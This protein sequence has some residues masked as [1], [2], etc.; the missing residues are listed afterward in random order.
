[1]N[2]FDNQVTYKYKIANSLTIP[3]KYLYLENGE[4][5]S[6]KDYIK[7]YIEYYTF[8]QI[9]TSLGLLKIQLSNIDILMIYVYAASEMNLHNKDDNFMSNLLNEISTMVDENNNSLFVMYVSVDSF[10]TSFNIWFANYEREIHK[11]NEIYDKIQDVQ[12]TLNK[13]NPLVTS[14]LKI[15]S[16]DINYDVLF[17]NDQK[18]TLEDCLDIFVSAIPT[19]QVP[20][21]QYN[22]ED[23]E[24]LIRVYKGLS[25]DNDQIPLEFTLQ[26]ITKN[27]KNNSFYLTIHTGDE[28][29]TNNQNAYLK[30]IYN[31]EK[32]TINLPTRDDNNWSERI[33]TRF[34]ESFPMLKLVQSKEN[35]IEGEFTITGMSLNPEVLHV[36]TINDRTISTYLYIDET[37]VPFCEKKR[38]SLHYRS[39]DFEDNTERDED[40]EIDN[41]SNATITFPALP[42]G[43]LLDQ[44]SKL[45]EETGT[46]K[47]QTIKVHLRIKD[48]KILNQFM[49][50]FPRL[51]AYYM[52]I[53]PKII[54]FLNTITTEESKN[55]IKLTRE[56]TLIYTKIKNLT[57]LAPEIFK[58]NK[59]ES[60]SVYSRR[61][62]CPY[63]PIIIS[64][65]EVE[66]WR[67]KYI[68]V[69]NEF[70]HRTVL[71]F[72]N[73][74][75]NQYH[76]VCPSDAYPIPYGIKNNDPNYSFIP[77]CAK[78]DMNK[79][80][81]EKVEEYK[82]KIIVEKEIPKSKE[83]YHTKSIKPQEPGRFG[84]L[85]KSLLS[86]LQA[87][88]SG[89]S[90]DF[91]H[92]GIIKSTSS[93]IHCL[94]ISTGDPNYNQYLTSIDK[95]NYVLA[96]RKNIADNIN[97]NVFKQEMYNYSLQQIKELLLNK[98]V[99]LDPHL[100]YRGLEEYFG[101]N[102]YVFNPEGPANPIEGVTEDT[103][104]PVLEIPRCI[105][106]HIRVSRPDRKT[107]IILKYPNYNQCELIVT[108]GIVINESIIPDTD[109]DDDDQSECCSDKPVAI[110]TQKYGNVPKVMGE[111]VTYI[112]DSSMEKVLYNS[113]KNMLDTYSINY[114]HTTAITKDISETYINPKEIVIHHNL[115]NRVNWLNVLDKVQILRQK[116]DSYGKTRM[117]EV[118]YQG[119]IVI[120]DWSDK[121]DI[122]EDVNIEIL[123]NTQNK[124]INLTYKEDKY[125]CTLYT[126]NKCKQNKTMVFIK[127]TR[128]CDEESTIIYKCICGNT[129][130]N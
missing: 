48:R 69:N 9:Y 124:T 14:E 80:R 75:A 59:N 35:K 90:Y 55:K 33:K 71:D 5:K 24:P 98:E 37:G 67:N 39:A 44:K 43:T 109:N 83:K 25:E 7:L 84:T 40:T 15:T 79:E 73:N 11:E 34:L 53:K 12:T 72:P 108:R 128:R 78:S 64:N 111:G 89:S 99:F 28:E 6:L 42:E 68:Q 115:Y 61:C 23:Q 105:I 47:N 102:I 36:L 50:I 121:V 103:T 4:F 13:T 116:I 114:P 27:D 41:S 65:D 30:I 88:F 51:M 66:A 95:E 22:Q 87:A 130:K 29:Y 3:S 129:W 21:I 113:L 62:T 56:N 57:H 107:V 77:C 19:A 81:L 119:N 58:D 63:Q 82:Q 117:L 52:Y 10:V 86:L 60:N 31:L 101:V 122:N 125:K 104:G 2:Q 92:W 32:G 100:F 126:C 45:S 106:T 96:I 127:Q 112:F 120:K 16:I 76:F 123:A 74:Q 1:M 20:F 93:L 91:N 97:L 49:G 18:I 94:C 85:P 26:D 110:K 46:E 70:H 17:A 38:F 54:D 118:D 8:S